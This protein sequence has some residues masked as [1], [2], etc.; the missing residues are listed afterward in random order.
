MIKSSSTSREM[1]PWVIFH[2][3]DD[4]T[5]IPS[6][7]RDQFVTKKKDLSRELKVMIEIRRD[8]YLDESTGLLSK[9]STD[10]QDRL[11]SAMLRWVG[12][13]RDM[14]QPFEN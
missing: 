4:S 9:S 12:L 1:P 3:P 11:K 7:V 14:V 6:E 8:L 10:V 2:T 5:V 13:S